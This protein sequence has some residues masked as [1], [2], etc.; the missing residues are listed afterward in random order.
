[1]ALFTNHYTPSRPAIMIGVGLKKTRPHT[2]TKITVK[3]PPPPPPPSTT[4][5]NLYV[6]AVTVHC[7][8]YGNELHQ[9]GKI[10]FSINSLAIQVQSN[11]SLLYIFNV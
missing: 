4:L 8:I 6:Q 5:V 3:S 7:G 10:H 11:N 2:R 1:M 9:N